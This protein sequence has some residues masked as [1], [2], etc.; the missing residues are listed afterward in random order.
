MIV[1]D[2]IAYKI[3]EVNSW[4]LNEDQKNEVIAFLKMELPLF[5]KVTIVS[6]NDRN[7]ILQEN[8]IIYFSTVLRVCMFFV[9]SK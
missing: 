8:R 1:S 5:N 9:L 3:K 4:G 2:E 6:C 7:S